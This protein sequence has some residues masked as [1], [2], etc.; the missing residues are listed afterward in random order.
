MY[1]L[2]RME[3]VE[4]ACIGAD[5][6]FAA[7]FNLHPGIRVKAAYVLGHARVSPAAWTQASNYH[8][9]YCSSTK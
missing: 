8:H 3:M 2:A 4:H 5:Y 9:S 7:V 6:V 1:P